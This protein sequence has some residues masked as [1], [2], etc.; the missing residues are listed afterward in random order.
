MYKKMRLILLL[1]GMG[2]LWLSDVAEA[3]PV[4]E[5]RSLHFMENKG[6][7]T[8]QHG[9]SRRDIDFRIGDQKVNIFIGNGRLHYQWA[10]PVKP[11]RETDSLIEMDLYRMDVSLLGCNPA[12]LMVREQKTGYYERYYT[13]PAGMEGV[14]AY[15]YQKII[16]KEIYPHIDWVLYV[17]NNVLEYDFVIRPGGNVSDIRIQYEGASEMRLNEDGSLTVT[18]P[19]GSV[20]EAAPVSFQENG[21]LVPSAFVLEEGLLSFRTGAYN[22][23]LTIDPTLSWSTYFGGNAVEYA[24]PGCLSGDRFGNVYFSGYTNSTSNLATTGSFQETWIAQND[25]FLVRLDASGNRRW[26]TY[27]GSN[28]QDYGRAVTADSSGGVYLAGYT[29][30]DGLATPGSHAETRAGTDAFLVKFDTAGNRLWATY[31]GGPSA[32]Y[33]YAVACDGSDNIYLGGYT[34]NSTSGIATPGA[35]KVTPNVS[36]ANDAFLVKFN[37]AGVRQW[38]TYFGGNDVDQCFSLVCDTAKNVIM[39]GY[40][41]SD[42]GIATPGAHQTVV[43]GG[44][45]AFIVKFDSAGNRIWST[46]FGGGGHDMCQ[47]ISCDTEGNLAVVGHTYSTSG[48]STSNAYQPVFAG[49]GP[50]PDM[51]IARFSSAGTLQWGTYYGGTGSDWGQ[52][53]ACGP[54]GNIYVTGFTDSYTAIATPGAFKDTLSALD[55]G[56]AV[57]AKFDASGNRVWGSYFGGEGLDRGFGVWSDAYSRVFLA[58][59]TSSINGVSTP[60]AFQEFSNGGSYDGFV[61]MIPDCDLTPPAEV[62]GADT[63]CRGMTYIYSVPSFPGALSYTWA[64]PADWSGSSSTNT[65]QVVPGTVSDTLRVAV[66]FL[67]GTTG[68][69]IKPV[70]VTPLP[71]MTPS[72]TEEICS[73]DT[74]ILTAGSGADYQWLKESLPLAGATNDY[75]KVYDGGDYSVLVTDVHGCMDTSQ[76]LTVTV[77]PLPVP[78]I[79]IAGNTLSTGVYI[80]YQWSHDGTPITGAQGSSYEMSLLSGLYTVT[81]TDENGCQGTSA[82]LDP[83]NLSVREEWKGLAVYPNP[84]QEVLYIRSP[85][86]VEATLFDM[87]GRF[88][89]AYTAVQEIDFRTYP[90]GVYLLKVTENGRYL[91]TYRVVKHHDK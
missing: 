29:S 19:A 44:E 71:V 87:K 15:A 52:G 45:D 10:R 72:G 38:G 90:A 61:A 25:A 5:R 16:Y 13:P 21:V 22:G 3:H 48:I 1:I 35:Y 82:P 33:G 53:I 66:H 88:L 27:Y 7:V 39:A 26:A 12:S 18:T 74:L 2:A 81:V 54:T 42:T 20:T 64:V 8:D 80:S 75:L 58:G 11:A 47:A 91:D 83:N 28:K 78:V 51:F 79:S 55:N 86:P 36:G 60:G 57:I 14:A 17:K 76:A 68:Q 69:A 34:N 73:G 43:G 77:H 59:R 9:R 70:F 56:D 63:V 49:G 4:K 50:G 24:S 65:I 6:Q 40:T 67:C 84:V 85:R 32:E 30:G 23:L 89:K 62:N 37:K 31:Y 41:Y 46:Y